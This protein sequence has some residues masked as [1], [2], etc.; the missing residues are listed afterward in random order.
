MLKKC[1]CLK[2]P[3]NREVFTHEKYRNAISEFVNTFGVK[4]LKVEADSPSLLD[5]NELVN[6]F[7]DHS[8][9]S[10]IC[11]YR[12]EPEHKPKPVP[13][14]KMLRNVYDIRAYIESEL[15]EGRTIR[16][17]ELHKKF[18]RHNIAVST[19]YRHLSFVKDKLSNQGYQTQKV[20]VGCYRIGSA[21]QGM[22]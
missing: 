12:V 13:R 3:D 6:Y 2:L 4:V 19:I 10:Y 5:P 9:E 8:K 7:C 17:K 15:L 21:P 16:I 22:V 1:L 11:D 14:E 20:M 18:S